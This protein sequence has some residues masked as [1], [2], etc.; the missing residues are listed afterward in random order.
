MSHRTTARRDRQC[1]ACSFRSSS[2]RSPARALP[3]IANLIEPSTVSTLLIVGTA[4]SQRSSA[5][6]RIGFLAV[7]LD[8][9]QRR[10]LFGLVHSVIRRAI[11][12]S[13]AQRRLECALGGLVVARIERRIAG[14]KN[15]L[16]VEVRNPRLR[17][18]ERR[19][20]VHMSWGRALELPGT[21][22]ARCAVVAFFGAIG[23]VEQLDDLRQCVGAL[24]AIGDSRIVRIDRCGSHIRGFCSGCVAPVDR[25]SGASSSASLKRGVALSCAALRARRCRLRS[26]PSPRRTA[27][28]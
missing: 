21:S 15:A 12:G 26:S 25:R 9:A 24:T 17:V 18:G 22:S 5:S 4:S 13:L 6:A 7:L 2:A 3:S 19:L 27:A 11:V 10:A 1:A 20:A 16:I 8:A 14:R 23:V 28:W